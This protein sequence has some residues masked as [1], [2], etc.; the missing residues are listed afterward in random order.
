MDGAHCI[1]KSESKFFCFLLEQRHSK[2]HLQ[3]I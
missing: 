3:F 1:K 2:L